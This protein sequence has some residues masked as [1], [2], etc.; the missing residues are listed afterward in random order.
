[1]SYKSDYKK[2]NDVNGAKNI[3]KEKKIK[4]CA[5][6]VTVLDKDLNVTDDTI[7]TTRH[8]CLHFS[9]STWRVSCA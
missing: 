2:P 3:K 4:E 7:S 1:M 8:V 9:L 5:N 6:H